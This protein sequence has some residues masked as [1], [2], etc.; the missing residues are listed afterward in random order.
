MTNRYCCITFKETFIL[1]AGPIHGCKRKAE[2]LMLGETTLVTEV[3]GA[4][5]VVS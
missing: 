2:V 4:F 1:N 3:D 5:E